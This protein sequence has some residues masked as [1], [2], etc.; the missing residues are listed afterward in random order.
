MQSQCNIGYHITDH[1][2]LDVYIQIHTNI[3]TSLL[4]Y[5]VMCT[6]LWD[7][8]SKRIYQR[9]STLPHTFICHS[10][11]P[12]YTLYI[13]PTSNRCEVTFTRLSI[14]YEL[15]WNVCVLCSIWQKTYILGYSQWRTQSTIS[16]FTSNLETGQS[17]V[18]HCVAHCYIIGNTAQIKKT[19]PPH[20]ILVTCIAVSH[21]RP[22]PTCILIFILMV[23][24]KCYQVR[25][26]I[27]NGTLFWTHGW[28]SNSLIKPLGY[29]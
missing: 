20:D 7:Y 11:G 16:D 12:V 2:N 5:S 4:C 1:K 17:V 8:T 25:A 21:V 22:W 26:A 29:T 3:L 14:S 9:V 18:Y 13:C 23:N 10:W 28:Q 24:T 15:P 27:L 19:Q 6:V